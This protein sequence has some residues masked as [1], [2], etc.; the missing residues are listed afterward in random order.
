[1][2]RSENSLATS[3]TI[4]SKDPEADLQRAWWPWQWRWRWA[5]EMPMGKGQRGQG[6]PGLICWW[7]SSCCSPQRGRWLTS[8]CRQP[9]SPGILK[10]FTISHIGFGDRLWLRLIWAR[11]DRACMNWWGLDAH[12]ITCFFRLTSSEFSDS[13]DRYVITCY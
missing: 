11:S 6:L 3:F 13:L 2:L 8:A 10:L 5:D 4:S 7:P 9:G 12:A 1:M